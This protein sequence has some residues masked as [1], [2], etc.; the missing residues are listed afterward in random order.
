VPS[1]LEI[2]V[3]VQAVLAVWIGVRSYRSYQGRQ[4]STSRIVVFP[5]LVLLVYLVTQLETIVAVPWAFPV[6]TAV[7]VVVLVAAALGTLPLADRLVQVSQRKDGEW[8]YQYGVEL[9]SLYLA[10]WVVRLGLAAYFDPSS[11]EFVAPTGAPLSATAS[12]V[13]VL[14]Q[15]LFSVSSGLVVGRAIGTYRL[16][17]RAQEQLRSPGN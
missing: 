4:Y 17:R 9:I 2:G 1:A 11:I 7:D 16:Q 3:G 6:W 14:I 13:L 10:L 8:Y 15:G 5:A 12:A